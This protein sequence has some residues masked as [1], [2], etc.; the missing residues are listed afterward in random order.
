MVKDPSANAENAEGVSSISGSGRPLE[1]EMVSTPVLFLGNPM[2]INSWW[3]TAHSV[4]K[5]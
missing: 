4:T 1:E 2:D 5:S 3:A